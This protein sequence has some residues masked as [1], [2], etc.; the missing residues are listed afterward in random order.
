MAGVP[1]CKTYELPLARDYVRHWGMTEAVREL[2]QNALDSDSPF[3]YAFTE[4]DGG[5]FELALTSRFA[6]LSPR[7]LVLG[8]TS[9]AGQVGKIGSFGEGYKLAL[10]VLTRC[11]YPV[12]V[13][14]G[15]KVW[16]PAFVH[17]ASFGSEVL[18]IGET[19]A[20][21]P[22]E[23]VEF[24]IGRLTEGD[25]EKIR[26]SCLLMQP[27]MADVIGTVRGHIL[28]GK[29]GKL[30]VGGL[31]VCHTKL[32]FGYDIRPEYL[33]LERD[34]QT[35]SDFDLKWLVKD[36]W[37]NTARWDQIAELMEKEVPD[38]EYAEHGCPELLANACAKKFMR[39]N[40]GAVA[41]TS[42]KE[43]DEAVARGLVRNVYVGGGY[44][45]VISLASDYRAGIGSAMVVPSPVESLRRWQKRN[46]KF[47]RCVPGSEIEQL[48]QMAQAWGVK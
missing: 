7:T 28:P 43:R 46:R 11:G 27:P 30:Y 48:N 20:E 25:V 17:S 33:A 34:R 2:I 14:N 8:A 1:N 19:T 47:L 10:L 22:A 26:E 4:S 42:Q 45:A 39:E 35:V 21:R 32:Y 36:M 40:P 6:S 37:F 38:L 13:H 23:G 18:A 29:P 5:L 15:D 16:R 41:V 31:L 12:A 24:V 44:G 9:K 3:E